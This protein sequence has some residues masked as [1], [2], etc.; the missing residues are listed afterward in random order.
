MATYIESI[1]EHTWKF[2]NSLL[3]YTEDQNILKQL[4]KI[5]T[6]LHNPNFYFV[7]F[8]GNRKGISIAMPG[9]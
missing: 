2:Y 7:R 1:S 5:E 4:K 6:N 8:L 3:D 9:S